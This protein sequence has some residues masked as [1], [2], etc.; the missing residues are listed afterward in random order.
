[1][2]EESEIDKVLLVQND[3]WQQEE[4]KRTEEQKRRMEK[5]HPIAVEATKYLIGA[6]ALGVLF[7]FCF[8][9]YYNNIAGLVYPLFLVGLY[10]ITIKTMK[11]QG[12]PF[13]RQCK[14]YVVSSFL[15]ALSTILTTNFFIIFLNTVGIIVLY[16]IVLCRCYLADKEMGI[17]GFVTALCRCISGSLVCS[18]FFFKHAKVKVQF[19]RG[20]TEKSKNILM[21]IALATVF[22]LVVLP[23]LSQADPVFRKILLSPFEA[24]HISNG[25]RF[26]R[27]ICFV[28]IPA[29]LFYGLSCACYIRYMETDERGYSLWKSEA[30]LIMTSIIAITYIIFCSI[31]ITY[32]FGGLFELPEG[33]TYAEY[34]RQGFWQLLLVAIINIGLVLLLKVKCATNHKLNQILVILSICTVIMIISSAYRMVLYVQV[35]DLTRLRLLVLWFLVLLLF[36]VGQ[37]IYYIYHS[38]FRI[39]KRLFI[40]TLVAYMI[41]S[42]GRMDYVIAKYNIYANTYITQ[43]DFVYLTFLSLDATPAIAEISEDRLIDGEEEEEYY[44]EFDRDIM[45]E[46]KEYFKGINNEYKGTIRGFNV[47]NYVAYQ[48]AHNKVEEWK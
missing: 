31:Q 36:I 41:L 1:M 11:N 46:Y 12:I 6:I 40:T 37:I 15:L 42:F 34:A 9:D 16:L 45:T 38:E 10:I 35:Y 2:Q 19:K 24:I 13:N 30:P 32:L 43:S 21:G 22:L 26:I 27:G 20:N 17:Q 28:F 25:Y 48:S 23:L 14:G 39:G 29:I 5:L 7:Y 44:N 3:P 4:L 18:K 47:S 33:L 8:Y